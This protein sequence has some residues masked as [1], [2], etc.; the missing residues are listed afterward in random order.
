ME[1]VEDHGDRP[2]LIVIDGANV[3]YAY[4]QALGGA[5][6]VGTPLRRAATTA[7]AVVPDVRG[8]LVALRYFASAGLRVR[9]VLPAS[10]VRAKPRDGDVDRTNAMMDTDQVEAMRELQHHRVLVTAPP[11]DDDDSY[12]LTIARRENA[13]RAPGVGGGGGVGVGVGGG[14]AYVLSNDWFR[15]AQRRDGTGQLAAWLNRGAVDDEVTATAGGG[16]GAALSPASTGTAGPGRISYTFCD[17]GTMDDHGD[18]RLD[19]I[20]NPRH[21]LVAWIEGLQHGRANNG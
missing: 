16:N 3:A 14:R 10:W 20:P 2:A 6:E 7:A 12:A 19:I 21:P 8:I 9:V 1:G 15:D 11:A 18:R 17:L 5:D 13:R 4:G